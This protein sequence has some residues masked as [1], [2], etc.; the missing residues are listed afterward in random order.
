M[1]ITNK[2]QFRIR[3]AKTFAI[4]HLPFV[5][6]LFVI[7]LFVI[8]PVNA[9]DVQR[10][11]TIVPPIVETTLNPGQKTEGVL[12]VIN[13]STSPLTFTASVHD[14][15]VD[16]PN[17]IPNLLPVNTLSKRFSGASWIGIT[18]STFTVLPQSKQTLNYFLQVPQ[19]ARPGGH[20]A[21]V[22]YT[23]TSKLAVKGTGASVETKLGTLFLVTV[24]GNINE[25]SQV[26]SFTAN[27]FQEYGPVKLTALIANNGD[28][29]IKPIGQIVVSDIFGRVINQQNLAQFDIF[30]TASRIYTNT[31][32]SKIMIGRFKATLLASYGRNNNL[33]L[34]ATV[35]F[36]VFPWKIALLAVLILAA[37]VLGIMY[38]RKRGKKKSNP[39]M[40]NK[41]IS[42]ELPNGQNG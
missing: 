25:S 8:A 9:Q 19:D 35:Y 12:K 41:Q 3:K 2:Y 4:R 6:C 10:T 5:I 24:N 13:D 15:I 30:P 29:H 23:P 33:P 21:A 31:V 42:N 36:W 28:L 14:F 32:G 38:W 7:C 37:I 18:P 1:K 16:N 34:T 26:T 27:P 40:T 20:Y 39:E 11:F 22:V 17:G